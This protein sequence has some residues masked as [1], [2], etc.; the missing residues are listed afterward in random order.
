MRVLGGRLH[1]FAFERERELSSN[2]STEEVCRFAQKEGLED[3]IKIFRAEKV[4]GRQLL[5]MDKKYT[6]EVLG[7]V[8]VKL[9]QKL[10]IKLAENDRDNPEEH[11]LWGWGRASEGAL[12]TNPSKEITQP[13]K[14]KLPAD[15][16]V[17]SLSGNSTFLKH[18]KHDVITTNTIEEKTNRLEWKEIIKRRVACISACG[19]GLAVVAAAGKDRVPQRESEHAVV[20]KK[21]KLRTAKNIIDKI[22]W[23]ENINSAEFRVG[24]LDKYDGVLEMPFA[25]L[26]QSEIK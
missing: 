12:G 2:W 14:I 24:Y 26:E 17:H 10:A 11:I 22:T 25:E 8:N 5:D 1:F 3:Y 6:E 19:A 9:Q 18:I 15:Y 21:E 16:E 23:D 7:L 13:I 4:T 20:E